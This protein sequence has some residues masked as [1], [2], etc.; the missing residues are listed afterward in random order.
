LREK[1]GTEL[2]GSNWKKRELREKQRRKPGASSK[3][4]IGENGRNERQK[5]NNGKGRLTR[6]QELHWRKN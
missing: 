1:Q 5:P 2:G 6:Q 3:R 4:N